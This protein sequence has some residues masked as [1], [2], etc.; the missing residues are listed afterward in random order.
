MQDSLQISLS[1]SKKYASL[2]DKIFGV[3]V[4]LETEGRTE[5]FV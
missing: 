5:H 4:H 1:A 3:L 2:T